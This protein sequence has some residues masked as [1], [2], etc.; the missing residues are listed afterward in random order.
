MT[1]VVAT[2]LVATV[3]VVTVVVVV[4][5]A[6][7]AVET[8][9]F[10]DHVKTCKISGFRADGGGSLRRRT[11]AHPTTAGAYWPCNGTRRE[12]PGEEKLGRG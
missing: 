1:V 9:H 7:V 10:P 8:Q 6:A 2:A 3:V 11:D 5:A 12:L 4:A